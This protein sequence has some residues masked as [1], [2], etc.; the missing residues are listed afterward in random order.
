M[1]RVE[2]PI[3]E[4]SDE[5][6]KM[7]RQCSVQNT[8]GRCN[9][10]GVYTKEQNKRAIK[11][12]C[13]NARIAGGIPDFGQWRSVEAYGII[14]KENQQWIFEGKYGFDWN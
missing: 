13:R 12:E 11:G 6:L 4:L 10:L 9:M 2:I 14:R 8:D 1:A 7:C 3:P 5:A